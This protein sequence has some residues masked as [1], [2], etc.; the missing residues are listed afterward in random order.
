MSKPLV[1][2][3]GASS[4][5]GQALAVAIPFDARV[6]DVS[7]SG[8]GGTEHVAADLADPSSWMQVGD[9]IADLLDDQAPE[10]AVFIHAAGTLSPIGF[11]AEVDLADYAGNVILNSAAGQVLGQRFL[12]ATSSAGVPADVV[13][14]S[15]GAATTAYAGWSAYCAGKAALEQWVRAVGAEQRIRGGARVYAIAPGVLDTAMQ[16]QIRAMSEHE[17]PQVAKFRDLHAN[18]S[19]ADSD[20]V[21]RR[22]WGVL[23]SD[24]LDSGSVVDIRDL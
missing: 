22:I 1:V 16:D 8:G 18:G 19:L 12:A 21:A 2:I 4:G 23:E 17:F 13:M 20:D 10:R 14:I 15:S 3:T 24:E 7:R 6:V 9:A 11:A 5:L